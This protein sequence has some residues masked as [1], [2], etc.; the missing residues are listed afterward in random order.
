MGLPI[1][2]ERFEH[3]Q[4]EVLLRELDKAGLLTRTRPKTTNEYEERPF[5]FERLN[6]TIE[7]RKLL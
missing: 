3:D 7:S 6:A 1:E 2:G 5:V 4:L